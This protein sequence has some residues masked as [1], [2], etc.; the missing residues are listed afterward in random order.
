[1]Q[2]RVIAGAV[3]QLHNRIVEFNDGKFYEK[4]DIIKD[5]FQF[6]DGEAQDLIVRGFIEVYE[7]PKKVEDLVDFEVTQ[8]Y[9]DANPQLADEGLGVGSIIKLSP[10]EAKAAAKL[11]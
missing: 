8:A 6:T 11:K 5:G 7:E 3:P 1:M 2:Y 10:K 9:F 4:G